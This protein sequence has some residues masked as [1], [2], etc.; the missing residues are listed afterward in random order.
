MS[1]P[2]HH[3]EDLGTSLRY[4][5]PWA[6][7]PGAPR[8]GASLDPPQ[9]LPRRR[10]RVAHQRSDF[11]GDRAMKELQRQLA[12]NPDKVPEPPFEEAQ[13]LWPVVLRM[14]AVVGVAAIVAGAMV[15]VPG[16]RKLT[17]RTLQ[18]EGSPTPNTVNQVKV[19]HV[20]M[21]TQAPL[22]PSEGLGEPNAVLKQAEISQIAPSQDSTMSIARMSSLDADEIA[23]LI[24]RGQDYFQNGDLASARLLLRRAAEAGSADAAL[25]LGATFDPNVERELGV[26]GIEPDPTSARKWYQKAAALG[27]AIASQKLARLERVR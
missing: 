13:N 17:V 25:A 19:V 6:R 27:S 26:V 8:V 5:P 12:L 21:D 22:I 14:C 16:T 24:K 1:S 10:Q 2:I 23:M 4:A 3:T 7:R 20:R 15:L 11:S 18:D 9:A